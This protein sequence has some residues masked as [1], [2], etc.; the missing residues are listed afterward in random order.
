MQTFTRR[1]AAV[2]LTGALTGLAAIA[3]A[4]VPISVGGSE[5]QA[6]RATDGLSAEVAQAEVGGATAKDNGQ[7]EPSRADAERQL[8]AK[9]PTDADVLLAGASAVSIFPNP[10]AEKGEYWET[11]FDKCATLSEATLTAMGGGDFA[12]TDH[13]A[14]TG[15]PWPENPNCIYMGG[16]GIGPMN[17][18]VDVDDV[19]GLYVRTFAAVDDAGE[20]AVLTIVDGEGWFWD[21][22]TKCTDCGSKEIAAAM[23]EELDIEASGIVVAATHSHTA[24]DFIGGWGFVPDWYMTQVTE[25]I[26]QSIREAVTGAKPAVI[27]IGEERAREFNRE[28]RDTYRSAEEQQISWFRAL[29]VEN[30]HYVVEGDGTLG[31]I[32]TIGAY[33]AHPT[34][35]GTNGGVGHADWPG[36][37][38][39]RVEERFGGVGLHF[40]TGLGNM[41]TSGGNSIGP[42]LADRLPGTGSG[43]IL[44][45]TNIE[46]AQTTWN[47]PAT[48]V[49]L[50][51]LALPGF[52]DHP[53]TQGPAHVQTGPAPDT[54]PC[55][56]ASPVSAEVP[57]SAI[58]IG[59]DLAITAAPGEVFSN[60]TNTVKEKSGSRVTL[61]LGQA[62]DALGYMPQSFEINPVGQQGLGFAAGGF[63]FV[64]YEDSYSIDRCF[65]DMALETTLSLLGTARG[66]LEQPDS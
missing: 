10:D 44:T 12:I 65:G 55:V 20:A 48:N 26:K 33:A 38:E 4:V 15:S 13:L 59:P 40:M 29:E 64:N 50:T 18:I 56:S 30:G 16:Y 47:Q 53:I 60:F 22:Q 61:P 34:S 3:T 39:D 32:A 41:S 2:V 63:L 6:E 49:P 58:L 52:F 66:A 5:S 8:G 24:P 46:S 27:E 19:A 51:A 42:A 9:I 28:R 54:A 57:A 31:T 11:D 1:A 62:N 14:S 36:F 43:T 21:Y 17:P 7:N 23:A 37:F 35:N 45:D 25:A